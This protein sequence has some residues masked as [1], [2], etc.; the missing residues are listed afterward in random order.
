M[1]SGD[2]ETDDAAAYVPVLNG[3]TVN[4]AAADYI[5]FAVYQNSGGNLA[6]FRY[7]DAMVAEMTYLG[8]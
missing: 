5:E 1:Y 8:A 4:L 3:L 6:I 2:F 7:V